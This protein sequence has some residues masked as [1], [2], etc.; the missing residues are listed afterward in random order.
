MDQPTNVAEVNSFLCLVN[1]FKT[2]SPNQATI[3]A[4]L[5]RLLRK[6]A[7]F[8]IGNDEIRAFNACK[9]A[10]LKSLDH[11]YPNRS[12]YIWSDAAATGCANYLSQVDSN[13][14]RTLIKC[15]SH[16][17]SPAEQN[18]S[19]LE[20]EALGC[21]LALEDNHWYVYNNPNVTLISDAA[22]V[23]KLM[24]TEQPKN[25]ENQRIRRWRA[26]AANYPLV[27]WEHA[28]GHKNIADYLSRR[29]NENSKER[30]LNIE[31]KINDNL[32]LIQ[33]NEII[34]SSKND[35]EVKS[36]LKALKWK[37]KP[38]NK[39]PFSKYIKVWHELHDAGNGILLKNDLICLPTALRQKVVNAAHESHL[40]PD[41]MKRLLRSIC[42]YPGMTKHIDETIANCGPCQ[43]ISDNTTIEPIQPTP[44]P[45]APWKQIA[46]DFSSA[47][48]SHEYVLA[49]KDEYS[50]D[51]ELAITKRLTAKAAIYGAKAI[52]KK[53]GTPEIVKSDN[54]PAFI[55]KEWQVFAKQEGFKHRK[56]TPLNPAANGSA[57]SIMRPIN[58][59]IRTAA[60]DKTN[61]KI[62]LRKYLQ[63]YKET[64]HTATNFSP[65][66]ICRN[67]GQS[68]IL[69]TLKPK[70]WTKA[71]IEQLIKYNKAAQTRMR[72]QADK[73]NRAKHRKI[74]KGMPVLVKW[75]KSNKYMPTFDPS[76]YEV[77][78]TKGTM[79][80]ANRPDH[81]ITRNAKFFKTIT[82][83]CFKNL[84]EKIS[85]KMTKQPAIV[86]LPPL[87]RE[88]ESEKE[89]PPTTQTNPDPPQQSVT[90]AGQNQ[91]S[92]EN[93][94][95]AQN[96]RSRQ[97]N[98]IETNSNAKA[99]AQ[100][101]KARARSAP[102][103]PPRRS[104]RFANAAPE[105]SDSG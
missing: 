48:P 44:L 13:N 2:R 89:T 8:Q 41:S 67:N 85:L 103:D 81:T 30:I 29:F 102:N 39:Q 76:P 69:H 15:G 19:H 63:R 72:Q 60:I 14:K 70:E 61:W 40:G 88:H 73:Y 43:T 26:R 74:E 28:A 83:Q 20:K 62:N 18:Y 91:A 5:R 77:T 97:Q 65:N 49:A 53:H 92:N 98:Q 99:K 4:P 90:I 6:N 104:P 71:N 17:W 35:N 32:P 10:V 57:E 101:R 37:N 9:A 59:I 3:E 31:A 42:W 7:K 54:G 21:I 1:Y 22:A 55:A 100:K 27:K 93:K 52:F 47:T 33:L 36:I 94:S 34:E 11:F 24:N 66:L 38:R 46:I 79:I 80:T 86:Y 84:K 12:T 25:K 75:E 56:I 105:P 96:T 51:I 45:K 23:I 64:P 82:E 95:P 58:R 50:K 16:A 78:A 87:R 68:N